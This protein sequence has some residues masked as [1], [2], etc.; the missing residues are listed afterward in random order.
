MCQQVVSVDNPIKLECGSK[1]Q[2]GQTRNEC[3]LN[4][5]T[6][7]TDGSEKCR[8]GDQRY[9][10]AD[11]NLPDIQRLHR[12]PGFTQPENSAARWTVAMSI[13]IR[14]SES[15]A[16]RTSCRRNSTATHEQN[17][18]HQNGHC[19]NTDQKNAAHIHISNAECSQAGP[20]TSECKPDLPP[21][22]AATTDWAIRAYETRLSRVLVEH[23]VKLGVSKVI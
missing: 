7:K 2:D 3:V 23:L 14:S 11:D 17:S 21:A 18:N 12:V 13:M 5:L 4:S 8:A 19:D 1:T 9:Q 20:L 6:L 15:H 10:G 22:L 16:A